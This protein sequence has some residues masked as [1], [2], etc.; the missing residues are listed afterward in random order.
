[1]PIPLYTYNNFDPEKTVALGTVI[2]KHAE[3]ISIARGAVAGIKAIFG[4][5]A[6][7]IE[8]KVK[9]TTDG[10]MNDF[11]KQVDKEYPKATAVIGLTVQVSEMGGFIIALVTGTAISNK[12]SSGGFKR[13][14]KNKHK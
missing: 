11:I 5:K 3:G 14:L 12:S 4:G 8:K 13:T 1:M 6:S 2:G 9:D 7:E 10:A